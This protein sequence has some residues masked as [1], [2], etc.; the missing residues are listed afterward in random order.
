MADKMQCPRCSGDC[1]VFKICP[2]CGG[3]KFNKDLT[4]ACS[5]CNGTGQVEEICSL[6][7]GSGLV[8]FS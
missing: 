4:T 8:H 7:H 5:R 2:G 1:K 3:R 6:C